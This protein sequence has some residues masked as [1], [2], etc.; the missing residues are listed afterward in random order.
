[1]NPH[2]AVPLGKDAHMTSIIHCINS[3]CKLPGI[4]SLLIRVSLCMCHTDFTCFDEVYFTVLCFQSQVRFVY[5]TL[6]FDF[7]KLLSNIY[8]YSMTSDYS[9]TLLCKPQT[10]VREFFWLAYSMCKSH[11]L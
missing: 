5:I 3:G 10:C 2:H 9:I 6:N 4:T 8:V 11:T 7:F 1:M